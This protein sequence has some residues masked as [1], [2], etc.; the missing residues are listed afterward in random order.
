L[1]TLSPVLNCRGPRRKLCFLPSDPF[2][3]DHKVPPVQNRGLI[4]IPLPWGLIY[5]GSI[6]PKCLPFQLF[7]ESKMRSF[8]WQM[9]LCK[10]QINLENFTSYIGPIS[11]AQLKAECWRFQQHF[12]H[13]FCANILAPKITKLYF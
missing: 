12:M 10:W 1:Y 3:K 13:T 11:S 8:L 4:A 5:L 9:G 7:L 2:Q 6:S